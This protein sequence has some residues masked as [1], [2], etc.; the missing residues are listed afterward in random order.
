MGIRIALGAQTADV[1]G[2]VLRE[3]ATL[4]LSGLALG[5]IAAVG[6]LRVLQSQLYNTTASDPFTLG[7]VTMLLGAVAL[8][9]CYLPARKATRTD[10]M[11][12]LR[13]E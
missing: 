6:S 2:L 3:G 1:L 5:L 8:L 12:A 7:I 4:I 9:A 10:P 13:Y 11:R